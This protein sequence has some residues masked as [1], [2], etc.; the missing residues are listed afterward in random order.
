[1]T[2]PA[3]PRGRLLPVAQLPYGPWLPVSEACAP[4]AEPAALPG[5]MPERVALRVVADGV[6]R[7]CTALVCAWDEWTRWADTA[8]AL[9]LA[10]LRFARC[11][12]E[13]LVVGAPLPGL[14][15]T[16]CHQDGPLLLPAGATLEPACSAATAR[17]VFR[18]AEGELALVG[19]DGTWDAVP[20][21]ALLA[22]TRANVRATAQAEVEVDG[23]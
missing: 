10:P 19:A 2:P 21:G 8:P 5:A 22:A 14:P 7:P 9:R 20:A 11:G 18:L 3:T 16:R 4:Q 1:M 15:G 12:A 23:G 17:R 13:A 6:E